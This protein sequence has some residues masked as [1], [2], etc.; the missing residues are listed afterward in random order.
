MKARVSILLLVALQFGC[1]GDQLVPAG[2]GDFRQPGGGATPGG[3]QDLSLAREYVA[4]GVVPPAEALLVEG[5]LSEHDL[6][7]EGDS[8]AVQSEHR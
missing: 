8:C 6:P 3:V 4:R 2:Q 7:L 1:G 5:M